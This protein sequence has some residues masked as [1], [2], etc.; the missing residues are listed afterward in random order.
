MRGVQ[1]VSQCV[2]TKIKLLLCLTVNL[3]T[4]IYVLIQRCLCLISPSSAAECPT[5]FHRWLFGKS[6]AFL[7]GSQST[8][9]HNELT[10]FML[11]L[12]ECKLKYKY[13]WNGRHSFNYKITCSVCVW[14]WQSAKSKTGEKFSVEKTT[15]LVTF[16][17]VSNGRK[18]EK[19]NAK[20][21]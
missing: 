2:M 1:L 12:T 14:W 7:G 11:I 3:T 21:I 6:S 13:Y 17:Y 9:N 5:E 10:S 16:S 15:V 18:K 4:T 8:G 20:K 19:I